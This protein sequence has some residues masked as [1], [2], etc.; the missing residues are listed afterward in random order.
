MG[1]RSTVGR[2]PWCAPDEG[3]CYDNRKRN[4]AA[5][6]LPKAASDRG[7]LPLLATPFI[8]PGNGPRSQGNQGDRACREGPLPG[9]NSTRKKAHRCTEYDKPAG[10]FPGLQEGLVEALLRAPPGNW[11]CP[12][13]RPARQPGGGV[14]Q[15]PEKPV[16]AYHLG[17][18]KERQTQC[19]Q[20]QLR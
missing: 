2:S 8:V 4:P 19:L 6:M 20:A 5:K 15:H 1:G 10:R 14:P 16:S 12:V 3:S 7:K 9:G 17:R 13:K 11:R 18:L